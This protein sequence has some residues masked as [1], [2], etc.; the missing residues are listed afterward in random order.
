M[1][2]HG[3]HGRSRRPSPAFRDHRVQHRGLRAGSCRRLAGLVVGVGVLVAPG[4]RAEHGRGGGAGAGGAGVFSYHLAGRP[5]RQRADTTLDRELDQPPD[6]LATAAMG[7]RGWLR[8]GV[9]IRDRTVGRGQ[10]T[11]SGTVYVRVACF[12]GA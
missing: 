7:V 5:C 9:R 1:R 4:A 2:E 8:R 6:L 10:A 12:I 3:V 11:V